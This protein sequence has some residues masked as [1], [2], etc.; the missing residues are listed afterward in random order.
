M[1]DERSRARK[2]IEAA[3][4]TINCWLRSDW[5]LYPLYHWTWIY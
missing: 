4:S 3:V 5:D 2:R 1:D